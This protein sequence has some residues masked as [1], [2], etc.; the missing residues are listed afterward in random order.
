MGT[1]TAVD[2]INHPPHYTSHPSGVESIE[3]AR[4]MSFNVGNAWKYLMRAEH[5]GTRDSDMKKAEWYLKDELKEGEPLPR[6]FTINVTRFFFK[7][8]AAETNE[9][10]KY[11][12]NC[13]YEYQEHGN[14]NAL[15]RAS[16][17]LSILVKETCN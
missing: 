13:L 8:V 10:I 2:L 14:T 3:V 7:V 5:K 11:I 4:Y 9:R 15:R 12:F 16:N 6:R 1:A 17:T